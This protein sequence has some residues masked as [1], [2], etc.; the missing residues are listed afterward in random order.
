M[1]EAVAH[2]P[3]FPVDELWA[4]RLKDGV[5]PTKDIFQ[6]R[7]ISFL[8]AGDVI[9]FITD[10]GRLVAISSVDE[11]P[12]GCETGENGNRVIKILRIFHD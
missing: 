9:K 12:N 4:K 10:E 8:V 5:Q 6:D 7:D 1:T 3:S 11:L 2:L